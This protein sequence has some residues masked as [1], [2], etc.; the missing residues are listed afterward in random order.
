MRRLICCFLLTIFVP[1]VSFAWNDTGH[2]TVA[3]VAYRQLTDHQKQ[4]I[5]EV[6]KQHPHYQMY[7]SAQPPQGVSLD[8]WVF[9]RAATWPDWVRPSRPGFS[10]EE[11]KNATITH[12]HNG[13]WHYVDIPY[14]EDPKKS[15]LDPTTLPS[16]EA[17]N[18]ITAFDLNFKQ[19]QNANTKPQ[20]RAVALAWVE[21]LVGDIHQPLHA[22][23]MF[24]I[25]HMK[26][27]KGGNDDAVR[28]EGGVINLHAFWDDSVG[29]SPD[30]LAIRF[31][32]DEIAGNK[33]DDPANIPEY[34]TDRTFS[35]WAEESY[36]AAIAM[37][38]L[39]GRLRTAPY[40]LYQAHAL[41]ASEVPALPPGYA[42][43]AR[44]FSLQRI[45]LAG[46]RL[47]DQL[48]MV[49]KD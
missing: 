43:A 1:A 3:L 31:N 23:S 28:V 18:A 35:S 11:Y 33:A 42:E 45:S 25:D 34:K 6:L 2:M 29:T 17:P 24:S 46:H 21:H 30:Y 44:G 32:A 5:A 4:Q 15:H 7:L 36:N 37:V 20:D 41:D 26:G 10:D 38:Y 22:T 40:P 39:D 13:A 19:L 12:Y 14:V 9:I 49:F 16:K 8:E 47:A 48:K 27:D